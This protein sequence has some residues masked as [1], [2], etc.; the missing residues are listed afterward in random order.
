MTDGFRSLDPSTGRLLATYDFTAAAAV[1]DALDSAVRA[2]D[3]WRR[4]PLSERAEVLRRLAG[5]LRDE[6]AEHAL[7]MAREMGKPIGE[8]RAEAEKCAWLTDYTADHGADDLADEPADTEARR[9]AVVFRPLG[10][11]LAIMP[12]NFPY[13]QVFRCAVP[14]LMAGNAVVLKHAPNVP[15]CA[16]A[17]ASLFDRAGLPAGL[18]HDLR[19]DLETTGKVIDD[20]RIRGVA[21]TGS[22]RAGRAVAA[23]AGAALKKTVL[24]LGGSDPYLI[25]ADAD[26]PATARACSTSRL[27]NGGQSCI[28]AKRFLVVEAVRERFEA[29]LIEEMATRAPGDPSD[30]ATR[31]GPLAREDLRANLDRQVRTS[32]D[33][34]ARCLLGGAVPDGPGFFYPPT[35]LT[36]VA[37]G[38]PAFDEEL[39]GPVAAVVP[40]ADEAEAVRLANATCYGLGAA[41]FTADD[42]RGERLAREELEAG[43]CFVNDFVRSD[44]RLPFG[45][46]R[47]S[48][49]G[50]ELARL[51]IREFVNAKTLWVR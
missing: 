37:P 50:R 18:F 21:L 4:W 29:S 15:E 47:D 23:R 3:G 22:T 6:A 28:A 2:Q 43:A 16:E 24:E 9:S 46:I 35:V 45:G 26:L 41:V 51:G 12:W 38:M 7:R 34:G 11:I 25:L 30:P 1:E 5:L 14:A 10:V 17:I 39:F 49:W 20:P 33:A 36:D 13:W 8:G 27:L 42:E 48:G 40:V 32:L 31:L 19:L 44:P